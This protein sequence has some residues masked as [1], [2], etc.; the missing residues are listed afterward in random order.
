VPQQAFDENMVTA[1]RER[2]CED[3]RLH[4]QWRLRCL[5]FEDGLW[6]GV[7]RYGMLEAV[8]DLSISS[9][10]RKG[11]DFVFGRSAHC[12]NIWP[13]GLISLVPET[14]HDLEEHLSP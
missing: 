11:V 1:P 14:Q 6:R 12:I 5:L 13:N 10:R 8:M 7:R 2:I 9:S 3:E 4:Q